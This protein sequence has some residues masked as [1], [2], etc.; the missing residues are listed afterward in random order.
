MTGMNR[1]NEV[2]PYIALH[3]KIEACKEMREGRR[4]V[5]LFL[6]YFASNG[7]DFARASKG[8]QECL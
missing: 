1:I 5:D 2:S 7:D 4:L 8:V 3:V 6:F